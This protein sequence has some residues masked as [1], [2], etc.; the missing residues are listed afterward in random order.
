MSDNLII[1][2][3]EFKS[4]LIL[5]TGRY[6][7]MEEMVS[8]V[9]ASGTEMITVALRRLDLDD[10]D[11]KTI[12]DYIDWS[13]YQILPNT[14]GCRTADEAITIARLARSMGLSNWIKLEVQPDARYLLPDPVGTLEAA[15]T[16]V[17]EGFVC[18]AVHPRRSG[19][20]HEAGADW[21]RDGDA[22]GFGH[23]LRAWHT[24]CRGDT[25]D[26]RAGFCASG[27]RR[28]TGRPIRRLFR[29][30]RWGPMQFW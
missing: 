25:D 8:A 28:R 22:P 18:A 23:R 16:L 15:R 14:A 10:P 26:S 30:W 3:K 19:P 9:E 21:M 6:R 13:R 2:G 29:R 12:L 24:H 7:T 5:G 1:A 11:K 27:G 20:G 17:D 4:R